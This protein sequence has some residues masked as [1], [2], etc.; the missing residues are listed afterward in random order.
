MESTWFFI[1][2]VR[3]QSLPSKKRIMLF[4]GFVDLFNIS[5]VLLNFLLVVGWQ[6]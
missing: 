6:K 5:D 3:F 2:R 1:F 4:C